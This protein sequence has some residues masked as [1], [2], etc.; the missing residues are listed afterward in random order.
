[1]RCPYCGAAGL[2]SGWVGT[3]THCPGCGLRMDRGEPD[4]FLGAYTINLIGALALGAGVAVVAV[5][6]PHWPRP[7]VYGGGIAAIVLFALGF[8]PFSRLLWLALDLAFR[9][10]RS[11]DFDGNRSSDC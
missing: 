11:S 9:G 5:A 1:M 6:R 7:L 10:A 2:R 8:Y 4:Y 3:V